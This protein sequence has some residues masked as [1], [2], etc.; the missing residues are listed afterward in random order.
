MLKSTKLYYFLILLTSSLFFSCSKEDD[1]PLVDPAATSKNCLLTETRGKDNNNDFITAC[2]YDSQQ[3]IIK[4]IIKMNG[5]DYGETIIKYNSSGRPYKTVTTWLTQNNI[6]DSIVYEYNAAGLPVKK[7]D[8]ENHNPSAQTSLTWYTIYEYNSSGK[9]IKES[10]YD[11]TRNNI[12]AQ[13]SIYS[14]PTANTVKEEFYWG[15]DLDEIIETTYDDKKG[16]SLLPDNNWS[17]SSLKENIIINKKSTQVTSGDITDYTYTY[18]FN[19]S[20]Y[21]TKKTQFDKG[22]AM[23]PEFFVYNCQ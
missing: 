16:F 4:T 21:P 12:L 2:E 13:Y 19:E 22:I 23:D 1:A 20:G 18:E 7:K 17:V 10:S 6:Q 5:V 14:Y 11:Y 9:L 3:R 8:Y 15:L